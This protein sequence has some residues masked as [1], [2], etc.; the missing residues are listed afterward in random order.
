MLRISMVIADTD[1]E[2]LQCLSE[3]IRTTYPLRIQV[4]AFSDAAALV[5][6]LAAGGRSDILL[7]APDLINETVLQWAPDLVVCLA[8]PE[9]TVIPLDRPRVNKYQPVR[10]L[11]AEVMQ[12]YSG[13]C[14]EAAA[15]IRGS[16]GTRVI[17]VYSPC[18]GTGKTVVSLG[19][20]ACLGRTGHRV[21]YLSLE[22]P[23]SSLAFLQGVPGSSL[24]SVLLHLDEGT[25]QLAVKIEAVKCRD[26]LYHFDY[27]PDPESGLEIGDLDEERTAMLVNALT[28]LSRY[29]AVVVDMDSGVNS[30][31]MAVL[32]CCHRV[33]LLSVP[34]PVCAR[35]MLDLEKECR[36]VGLDFSRHAIHVMNR[37]ESRNVHID[38]L[39]PDLCLPNIPGLVRFNTASERL[40]LERSWE[41]RMQVLL[42]MLKFQEQRADN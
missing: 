4:S 26:S 2:Y 23:V 16:T 36:R 14:R 3:Y 25:A 10:R 37:C 8:V 40:E 18:G 35:K 21:F 39:H 15:V 17:G 32:G 29:D 5:E 22:S 34:D 33:V 9:K 6:Y 20:A 7:I 42:N 41:G 1:R 30:R 11:V 24:S 27:L 12:L 31:N 19:L 13:N 28:G 38:G